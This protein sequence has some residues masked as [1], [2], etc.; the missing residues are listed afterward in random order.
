MSRIS[1]SVI[2]ASV[3]RPWFEQ[4][5]VVLLDVLRG[6]RAE[7]GRVL[8]PDGRAI[9]GVRLVKGEHL[10]PGAVYEVEP[11]DERRQEPDRLRI[12]ERRSGGDRAVR[13]EHVLGD[14]GTVTVLAGTLHTSARPVAAELHG[15][16]AAVGRWASLRRAQGDARVDLR[17]WWE[18]AAG[19]RC[20]G[21]P[22]EARL[23]HRLAGA[24]LWAVPRPHGDGRW[25]VRL[26]LS[27][28]GRSLLRPVAAVGLL[29]FRGRLRQAFADT[30][31][32]MARVWNATV[33]ETASQDKGRLRAR[34][35]DAAA[36]PPEETL[37]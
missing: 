7:E 8:L 22:F 4:A 6:I 17:A 13:L 37:L 31:D 19:R 29:L 33:P 26:V 12:V 18:A 20:N 28:R 25:E 14:E 21:T 10:A 11:E 30:V 35:L 27:L 5:A 15:S 34:I 32:R 24:T 3:P 23:E 9:P 2:V 1:H 36:S 16:M